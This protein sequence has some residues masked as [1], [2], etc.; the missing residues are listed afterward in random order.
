MRTPPRSSVLLLC[1]VALPACGTKKIDA[2]KV[3]K[4]VAETIES[5]TQ[6]GGV[7]VSCPGDVKAEKGKPFDC[8]AK[9][10]DG[11]RTRIRVQQRDDKG[12]VFFREPLLHTGEAENSIAA[13][14]AQ[15]TSTTAKVDCPDLLLV[16]A[17]GTFRCKAVAANGDKAAIN[18]T[19]VG[20][21]GRFTFKATPQ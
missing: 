2:G 13:Q 6:V 11:T 4:K 10:K 19:F 14:I 5:A 12:N 17:G 8:Q 15:Q 16:K 18:G 20:S 7:T 3:E 21:G 9:G 1:A